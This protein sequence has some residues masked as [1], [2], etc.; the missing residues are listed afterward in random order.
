MADGTDDHDEFEFDLT[1]EGFSS[2]ASD[3]ENA[4]PADAEAD[5]EPPTSY[6]SGRVRIIGA[7]PAGDAVREVTGPVEE[8]HPELPHWNDAPTGQ[9]PAI[10]DRSNGEEQRLAPPTWREE[11]N[12]WEAQEDVFEPS[13][14]SE[15]LPAVGALLGERPSREDDV[16]QPWHFESD[17]TLVIPPEPELGPEVTEAPP[18]LV[19]EEPIDTGPRR[20]V[21]SPRRARRHEPEHA[22][23]PE[24]AAWPEEAP[25][26]EPPSEREEEF[27]PS[28]VAPQVPSNVSPAASAAAASRL[29][30]PQPP[31]PKVRTARTS[32]STAPRT[33]NVDSAGTSGRDMRTAI[34]VGV[35]FGA[36]ALGCFA[37]GTVATLVLVTA[38]TLLATAEGY[39]AFRRAQYHPATLL[40]LVAVLSLMIETYNKGVAA[41]PLVLVLLVAGSFIWYLARVEPAADPVSGMLS[42]VFIFVWIGAFGSFAALLLNPTLFPDRHG[43]AFLL[44]AVIV[45]V[46]DDVAS[47]LVGSAMGRHQ[48]APSISPNKTWEGVIGGGLAAI[49]VAVVVVHFIHPWTVSKALLFGIVVAIVAP[50]GDLSQSMVKRHLGLKDMGRL[51]PGHG[52]VL[53][54]FDGLL[55][56]LPATY[57]VVKA[58]HLG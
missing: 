32:R 29:S 16:R 1:V 54:R 26:E 20:R 45:T 35:V 53:D 3:S 31:E 33:G 36:V 18:A 58:L 50:L 57:F 55:F 12:D 56:V 6:H 9:V 41:L 28:A 38:V 24:P 46:T 4:D 48:L 30:P 8:G 39:A 22:R 34:A 37:A 25:V 43:I 27:E 15:D 47:L 14:L 40:G 13:M 10:L 11:D 49:L 7:E 19:D 42:T 17:D 44:A 52:G 21:S 23:E 51:L 5:A 2:S